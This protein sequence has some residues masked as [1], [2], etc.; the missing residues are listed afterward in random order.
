VYAVF[1]DELLVVAMLFRKKHLSKPL[2]EL[3]IGFS[4]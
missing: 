4:N 1:G 2:Q 3:A